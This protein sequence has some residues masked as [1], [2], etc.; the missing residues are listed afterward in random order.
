MYKKL[1][2]LILVLGLVSVASAAVNISSDAEDLTVGE[3]ALNGQNGGTGW[4]GAWSGSGSFDVVAETGNQYL[5]NNYAGTKTMNRA[6]S[7]SDDVYSI[8]MDFRMNSRQDT[9]GTGTCTQFQ[10]REASGADPVHIKWEPSFERIRLGNVWLTDYG[11]IADGVITDLANPYTGWVTIRCDINESTG[12]A[13]LY[14]EG[15]DGSMVYQGDGAIESGT[16]GVDQAN[17]KW[18]TRSGGVGSEFDMDNISITPEPAT[19]MMLGLGGLALIR[20]KR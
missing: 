19:I 9:W 17:I 3:G 15:T 11:N 1:L 12:S 2:S 16:A 6:L 4:A 10:V 13:K 7:F 20:R 18:S 14:W 5:S 8:Q